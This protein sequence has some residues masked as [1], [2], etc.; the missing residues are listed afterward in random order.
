MTEVDAVVVGGGLIGGAIAFELAAEKLRVLVLDRQQP[1]LEASWAAAGMLAP[2]PD[3]PEAQPL[4]PLAKESLR[5]YPAFV[6]AVEE[7]SGSKAGF[8]REGTVEVFLAPQGEAERDAIIAECCCFGLPAEALTLEAARKMEPSLGPAARAAAWLPGEATVDP[9]LLTQA[10]LEAARQ[11]GAEIRSRCAVTSLVREGHRCVGVVAGGERMAA[12]HVI[13]AAG[14]YSRSIGDGA[15]GDELARYAPT[16]PVRGQMVA[17]DS[18][19]VG[20]RHV[21]RS[22]RGYL[23]PRGDRLVAGS[24]LENAGFEKRV[25]PAGLAQIL[26]AA[27]DIIPALA[28]AQVLESWAGLRPG[29]PD[30]LPILG[31]TDVEGLLI[32]TGHYR[33]GILL[34]PVTAKLVREW[35]TKGRTSFDAEIFS[36]LRFA[37]AASHAG[38]RREASSR[39]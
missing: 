2:G 17:L 7:A 27:R 31:P 8:A 14:C 22:S 23:V 28:D 5:L 36:P 13:I 10:T 32:A 33:N 26:E 29:T 9:R 18:R 39:S 24:T 15:T 11:R 25:T 38:V 21:V 3:S 37:A 1:G 4:V 12:G 35:I 6:A 30:A 20:L 19:G 34:G 16:H